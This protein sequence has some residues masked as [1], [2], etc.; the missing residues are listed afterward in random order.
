MEKVYVSYGE[1]LMKCHLKKMK[2]GSVI[3]GL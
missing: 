3:E 1:F 2:C